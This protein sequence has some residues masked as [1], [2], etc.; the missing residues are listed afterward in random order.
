[1]AELLDRVSKKVWK[2]GG[3]SRSQPGR[4]VLPDCSPTEVG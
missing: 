2:A 3:K 4:W 1:M